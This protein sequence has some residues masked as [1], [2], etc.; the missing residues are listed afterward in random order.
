MEIEGE[1]R[2]GTRRRLRQEIVHP[3][4]QA[5]MTALGVALAVQRLLGLAGGA[6]V[7]PGLYT[8]HVLLDPETVVRRLQDIGTLIRSGEG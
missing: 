3:A 1:A 7:A 2:D 6:P 4:G 8:P 5:P